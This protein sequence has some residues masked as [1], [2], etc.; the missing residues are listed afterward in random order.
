MH[1]WHLSI[2]TLFQNPKDCSKAKKLVCNIN[3]G[4]GYGCQLH[5]LTYCFIIAYGT[6]R[7]FILESRGWRYS[8]EG[9]EKYFLPLSETCTDRSGESSRAWGGESS[10]VVPCC[11]FHVVCECFLVVK[12][13]HAKAL[14]N[15]SSKSQALYLLNGHVLVINFLVFLMS[16]GFSTSSL[17]YYY[18]IFIFLRPLTHC[19]KLSNRFL[20]SKI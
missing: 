1:C 3:K 4:C 11:A 20:S 5:H 15:V 18:V 13:K 8:S 16:M 2:H 10:L 7:T 6:Q 19:L 9:W 14:I 17:C 12:R